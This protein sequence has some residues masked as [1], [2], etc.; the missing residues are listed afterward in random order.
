MQPT[1]PPP[2]PPPTPPAHCMTATNISAIV[3]TFQAPAALPNLSI[4][5]LPNANCCQWYDLVLQ[6][7]QAYSFH[8]PQYNATTSTVTLA[9]AVVHPDADIS[10]A[11]KMSKVL[12]SFGIGSPI[13]SLPWPLT[14]STPPSFFSGTNSRRW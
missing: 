12:D 11:V 4:P 9:L 5:S 2:P 1:T 14:P 10:F 8:H 13:P 6:H 3:A 7:I